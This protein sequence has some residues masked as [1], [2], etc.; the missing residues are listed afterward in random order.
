MVSLAHFVAEHFATADRTVLCGITL[1]RPRTAATVASSGE[2]AQLMDEIQYAF[3]DGPCLN[4]ARRRVTNHVPDVLE[5]D[6]PWAE[7]RAEI[8]SHGLRSILAV[9][10][11]LNSPANDADRDDSAPRG[12]NAAINLY[13]DGPGAFSAADISKAESLAADVTTT[14]AI[15]VR[16][17]GS[18][19][20]ADQLEAAMNSRTII[21]L[22]AGMIMAQNRCNQ[23]R[24]M[25]ILK[26]ASSARNIK[27]RDLAAS[28]VASVSAEQPVTHFD[29]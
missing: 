17:A 18:S 9:P 28:V 15:A 4:S 20:R 26:A 5:E 22:A 23:D 11:H 8:A 7:Y 6:Q 13:A 10:I 3:D 14:V 12:E 1:M 25:T 27:V 2:R 21:D 29:N 16:L 24:A 19:D